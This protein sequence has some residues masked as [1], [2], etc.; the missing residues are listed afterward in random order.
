MSYTSPKEA[1]SLSMALLVGFCG[2]CKGKANPC[3]ASVP[4][5]KKQLA[6]SDR[7]LH[8]NGDRVERGDE[9]RDE[10]GGMITSNH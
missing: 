4:G 10:G 2:F 5:V 1:Q 6:S 9:C 3:R 8:G 7:S